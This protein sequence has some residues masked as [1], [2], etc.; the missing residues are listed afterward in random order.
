MDWNSVEHLMAEFEKATKAPVKK[1]LTK[2]AI[3]RA[4]AALEI[5]DEKKPSQN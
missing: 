1:P 3:Q 4:I 2:K 5:R